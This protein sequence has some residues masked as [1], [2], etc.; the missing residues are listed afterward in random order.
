MSLGHSFKFNRRIFRLKLVVWSALSL[1]CIY[2]WQS[3]ALGQ[4]LDRLEA[5]PVTEILVE[6]DWPLEAKEIEPLLAK[7]RGKSLIT[8]SSKDVAAEVQNLNW[9]QDV[10]VRKQYPHLLFVGVT[11]KK[12]KALLLDGKGLSF[13]DTSGAKIERATPKTLAAVSLPIITGKIGD[14]WDI[15]QIISVLEK[16][17]SIVDS[18][19]EIS[20]IN[21]ASYPFFSLFTASPSIELMMSLENWEKQIESFLKSYHNSPSQFALAHRVNLLVAK[22]AVVSPHLSN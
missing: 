8:L 5:C 13:L 7:F 16:T 1:G 15:S 2:G 3:G 19:F 9:T 11:T 22:K 10:T 21:L 17:H 18:G 12:P 4:L 6:C 14:A 20:E